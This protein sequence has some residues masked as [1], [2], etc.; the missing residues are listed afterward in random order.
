MNRVNAL[1]ICSAL[2]THSVLAAEQAAPQRG[3]A[4]ADLLAR[5]SERLDKNFIVDPR[6]SGEALMFGIDPDRIS[7]RELQAVLAVHGYMTTQEAS[8]LIAIVPDNSARQRAQ[9]VLSEP[10]SGVGKDEMVTRTLDVGPLDAAQLVPVLRPMMPQEA[11]LVAVAQ[12][13]TLIIVDRYDNVRRIEAVIRDLQK[14]PRST[15][16]SKP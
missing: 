3:I 5:A 6:V 7:Y 16:P 4:L 13:N 2:I 14:R 9:P 15:M 11:H 1:I 12:T 10:T 8:G